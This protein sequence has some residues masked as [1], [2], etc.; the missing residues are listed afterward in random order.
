[1]GRIRQVETDKLVT[2]DGNTVVGRAAHCGI[3][4][5]DSRVSNE[6]AGLRWRSQGWS[7]R[8]LGS[9]NGT[10]L[11][12]QHIP[13]GADQPLAVADEVAFGAKEVLWRFEDN[14]APE[15]MLC[16]IAGGPPCLLVD[17]VIAIPN[18]E[19]AVASIFRGA[20]G[21]WTLEWDNRV[22]PIHAGEV[23]E[24]MGETWRFS[25]PNQWEA[26]SRTRPLRLVQESTLLFDVS[27][28]QEHVTLTVKY[29][30]E[31]IAM[32]HLSAYYFLLQLARVRNQ[33]RQA[34]PASESG[35]VHR[36]T[37][38]DMLR[39]GEQQLNVWV[40]RIRSRFSSKEF[41]DYASIIE[42]RDG[43]GQ[44]RIGVER[45]LIAPA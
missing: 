33:E 37:L 3:V 1:M 7:V 41:L 9:T 22:R 28:D 16:P 10:W 13:A 44:M 26:T 19:A 40:H 27:S 20:E 15:P 35:W 21:G 45:S 23:F 34:L 38:M 18:A 42:R 29:D 32:G 12:G 14:G 39:C 11:N 25:Y 43:T 17:G 5:R 36:E 4:L 24:M 30:D 31:M 6:H 8:D 2:L